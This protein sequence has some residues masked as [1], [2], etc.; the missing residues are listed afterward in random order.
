MRSSPALFPVPL[1][2]YVPLTFSL[3]LLSRSFSPSRVISLKTGVLIPSRCSR[4]ELWGVRFPSD[5]ERSGDELTTC[6]E[7]VF[8]RIGAGGVP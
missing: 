3:P 4:E 5:G 1:P 6:F 8:S 7:N 2:F